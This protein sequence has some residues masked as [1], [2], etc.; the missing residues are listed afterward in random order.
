MDVA[1]L[2][3]MVRFVLDP[4]VRFMLDPMVR[5]ALVLILVLVLVPRG[6]TRGSSGL[7]SAHSVSEE[8]DDDHQRDEDRKDPVHDFW[9]SGVL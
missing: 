6:G 2:G 5:F 9:V 4:V 7:A 8:R 3:P 1:V